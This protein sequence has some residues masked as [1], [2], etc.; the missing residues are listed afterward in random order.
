LLT[1]FYS[2]S[3]EP[4]ESGNSD[5]IGRDDEEKSQVLGALTLV[6]GLGL[7]MM[8]AIGICG[9]AG[10]YADKWLDTSPGFLIAGIFLGVAAGGIQAYRSILKTMGRH[11]PE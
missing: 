4:Y 3:T 5:M 11:G 9:V 1:Y 2:R 10:Y 8:V 6:T 7:T